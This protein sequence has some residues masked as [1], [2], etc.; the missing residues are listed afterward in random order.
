MICCKCIEHKWG[1]P[2]PVEY[3]DEEGK[4][5]CLFHAPANHKMID[6]CPYVSVE[7]FNL[8]VFNRINVTKQKNAAG[9]KNLGCDMTG[10]VFLG[11]ICFSSYGEESRMPSIIFT[12]SAFHG[13]VDFTRT[14]FDGKAIFMHCYFN[15]VASFIHSIFL[16]ET[17]FWHSRFCGAAEFDNS[18][19]RR[20]VDFINAHFF[21][22]SSFFKS[23]FTGSVNFNHSLFERDVHFTKAIFE[24]KSE[25][26]L[27][28]FGREVSFSEANFVARS[29]FC[30]TIFNNIA[31]FGHVN[32]EATPV[33]L[34]Q[35]DSRSIGNMLFSST[36]TRHLNFVQPNWPEI[37]Q[38]ESRKGADCKACEELYRSLKQKA[39]VE[40]D[41]PLVSKWHYREKLMGLEQVKKRCPRSW[42][43]HW[44]G[45]YYWTSGFGERWVPASLC[46]LGILVFCL[47]L[48]GLG[49]VHGGG[50]VINGPALPT[51]ENIQN[52]GSVCLSLLKYLL[53]IKE[54][55][56]EF[57][58]IYGWAEFLILLFTR[59]V[60]PIQSAFFAI[61][62]RNA[63][64]R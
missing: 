22:E 19:F 1:D 8:F 16:D 63:Y 52:F 61:A 5:Y 15:S 38:L 13:V 44:L 21:D 24:S 45:M 2:Q 27:T 56:I 32:T 37:L 42:W 34:F 57:K 39:A 33:E 59:L 12:S 55:S 51:W 31:S 3:V 6:G 40:H 10:V 64:R 60:I 18:E 48:L 25:F 7:T 28:F 43:L 41:Q 29:E 9:V 62:L 26:H 58:P 35:I 11:D 17:Y 50:F 23:I 30:S 46:L 47:F 20:R 36:D 53:L 49:G 4:G 54:E 14:V